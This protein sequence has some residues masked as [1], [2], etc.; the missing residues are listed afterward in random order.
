MRK[1]SS[2]CIG[3]WALW[4]CSAAGAG[5]VISITGSGGEAV[6]I[7]I[8]SFTADGAAIREDVGAI[9]R[10]DLTRS[11]FFAPVATSKLLPVPPG[12]EEKDLS[13]WQPLGAPTLLV[14]HVRQVPNGYE[15]DFRLYDVFKGT[16]LLAQ[17]LRPTQ[18][19]LRRAAHQI[20]DAVYQTLTGRSGMFTSRLAF[21]GVAK[22][23]DPK[24]NRTLYTLYV[25]DSDGHTLSS[26]L[27]SSQPI[28]GAAWSPDGAQL[29][30]VSFERQRAEIYVHELATRK[31]TVV[32][33]F[34]GVNSAPTW[35]PDGLRLAL[36]L[37][38]D[39]NPELYVIDVRDKS[40][41][42]LTD[43]SAIDTEPTWS[44][45]GASIVFTS[46]RG[47]RPQLYKMSSTGGKA[48]RL[49]HEGE[50]A[51]ATF[52]PDGKS[53]ALVHQNKQGYHIALFDLATS[54]L[55]LV[56]GGP[57]DETPSFSPNGAVILYNSDGRLM[58]V[59][60]QGQV[61]QT[62]AVAVGKTRGPAWGPQLNIKTGP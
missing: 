42:R 31:R 62:L 5:E 15:V 6:P 45:D 19:K 20:S 37:S 12:A 58:T 29:A 40:S 8:A 3:A 57:W 14:G 27:I 35:S 61:R 7:A 25:S 48:Q 56:S 26:L 47:G 54:E 28:T 34:P 49:T 24:K 21:V 30:Y 55:R 2:W 46:D 44:P 50:N 36:S 1:I 16:V 23:K 38:K 22:D 17:R 18:D 33:S 11:G 10:A 32:A 13:R 59:S 51:G 60:V 43:H 41:R 4:L 39:G 53:L 9:V 52:A